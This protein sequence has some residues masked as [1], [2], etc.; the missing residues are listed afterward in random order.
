M[1]LLGCRQECD[2]HLLQ[3]SVV[4][5]MASDGKTRDEAPINAIVRLGSFPQD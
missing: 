2:A 4:D 1:N 5:G 3:R